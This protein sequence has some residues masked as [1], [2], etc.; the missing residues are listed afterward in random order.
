LFLKLT[1]Q[2]EDIKHIV[3]SLSRWFNERVF[4]FAKIRC[5]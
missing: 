2:E 3:E 1:A 5:F 4:Y